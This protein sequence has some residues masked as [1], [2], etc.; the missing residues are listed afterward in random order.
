MNE[1]EIFYQTKPEH[2]TSDNVSITIHYKARGQG[3]AED[4]ADQI[5]A[6]VSSKHNI[7]TIIH[8]H[9]YAR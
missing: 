6:Y 8:S 7:K 5:T 3:L 2:Y 1:L 4:I 9:Q